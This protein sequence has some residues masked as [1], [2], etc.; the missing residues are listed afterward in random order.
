MTSNREQKEL[1]WFNGELVPYREAKIHVLSHVIHY[2]TGAF[3]GIRLYQNETGSC[4]FRLDDHVNRLFHSCK[5]Y[6]LTPEYSI[7]DIKKAIIETLRGN[8]LQKA[9]IRPIVF[10]GHGSLGVDPRDC[11]IE[12]VI[13][14][15]S[16][17]GV[18]GRECS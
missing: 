4:I 3:E 5:I 1:I 6:H 14:A 10:R 9:Y 12:T 2:G 18:F 17:G 11:P 8:D 13:A 15:W 7:E 16:W